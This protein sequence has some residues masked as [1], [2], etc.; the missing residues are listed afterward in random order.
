MSHIKQLVSA[1]FVAGTALTASALH[2]PASAETASYAF[3]QH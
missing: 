1:L 2:Q 3:G